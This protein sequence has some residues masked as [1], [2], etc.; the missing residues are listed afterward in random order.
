MASS[1]GHGV[2]YICMNKINNK[3]YIGQT[4][5]SLKSRINSHYGI[6][7]NKI[8][9]YPFVNALRK[10]NRD[11]FEWNVVEKYPKNLLNE[12]ETYW[13]KFY[14][15]ND[16]KFGYN[17]TDGGEGC[18][19]I[20]VS[21]ETRKKMRDKKLGKKLPKQQAAKIGNALRGRKRPE[22]VIRKIMATR[23]K[24][25]GYKPISQKLRLQTSKTLGGEPFIAKNIY[26]GMGYIFDTIH[27]ASR[28]LDI[29]PEKICAILKNKRESANTWRFL[30]IKDKNKL[31]D[32]IKIENKTNDLDYFCMK[33][34]R[35]DGVSF[36]NLRLFFNKSYSWDK[37]KE[38]RAI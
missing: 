36:P 24:R 20:E 12:R 6:L 17:R 31:N 5:R 26:S 18:R 1:R 7:N 10:Y 34:L 22:K 9:K 27:E 30:Y 3:I 11:D 15:S 28:F 21:S 19:N 25:G 4:I 38:W 32:K 29:P 2:I 13:I 33:I 14:K 35:E 23:L 37:L 8:M 16:G